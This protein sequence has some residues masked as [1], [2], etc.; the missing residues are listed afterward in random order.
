MRYGMCIRNDQLDFIKPMADIGYDYIEGRFGFFADAGREEIENLKDTLS[1]CNIKCECCNCFIPGNMKIT[2]D[3]VDED[4]LREYIE[5]GMKNA[6][7]VGCEIVVF[8]S[9][10]ARS[11]PDGY[12]RQK[13]TE[14]IISFLRNIVAPVAERYSITVVTEPL[15]RSECNILNTV[16]EAVQLADEVNCSCISSLGDLFHMYAENET[17]ESISSFVGKLKH[18][19]IASVT[20]RNFPKLS[21]EYDYGK[22]IAVMEKLGCERCSVE[23]RTDNFIKDAEEA[24]EVFGKIKAAAE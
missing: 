6:K 16:K 21:D 24:M 2:G 5:K 8:G 12:D 17:P 13:T 20:D 18:C 3:S 15:R 1:Q 23:G 22:F 9:S 19:H 10:G 4:A 7:E 14:Q 11:I